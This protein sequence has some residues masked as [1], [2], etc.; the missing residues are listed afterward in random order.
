MAQSGW[1]CVLAERQ[2]SRDLCEAHMQVQG[3]EAHISASIQLCSPI[4]SYS[5]SITMPGACHQHAFRYT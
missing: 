5:E 2:I 1:Y 4:S 3:C